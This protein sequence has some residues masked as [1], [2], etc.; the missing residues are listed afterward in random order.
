MH[1]WHSRRSLK[2]IACRYLRKDTS[3]D[4]EAVV[5]N[6]K[7][8]VLYTEQQFSA[9]TVLSWRNNFTTWLMEK[10]VQEIGPGM[11]SV[12]LHWETDTI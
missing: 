2:K 5:S 4:K 11:V 8:Y 7:L 1:D 9:E 6:L 10:R 12:R 3:F